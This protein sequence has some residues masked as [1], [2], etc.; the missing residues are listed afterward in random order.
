MIFV[1]NLA[2]TACFVL[3]LLLLLKAH[4]APGGRPARSFG[5][6]DS[7]ALLARAIQPRLQ[8]AD[9]EDPEEI[10][11][12]VKA[13]KSLSASQKTFKGLDGA[14]HEMYQRTHTVDTVELTVKGRATRSAARV[15]ATATA[16]GA[17]ELCEL[18]LH[19]ETIVGEAS[20]VENGTLVG[21]D[22]LVNS[23]EYAR[24]GH[25]PL[26]CLVLYDPSYRGPCGKD[27]GTI[28]D[29][30]END[31]TRKK[32][33]QVEGQ[34]LIA[35]GEHVELADMFA[36]L[37]TQP[38]Y[39][40]LSRGPEAVAI[41]PALHDAAST[42]VRRLEPVLREYNTSAVHFAGHGMAGGVASISAAILN[43][44]I[45]L[46]NEGAKK[47]QRKG[48]SKLKSKEGM[49][50]GIS[51]DRTSAVVLGCPPCFSSNVKA[52]YITFVMYGDDIVCRITP[53]SFERFIT[54][55]R[56]AMKRSG[57][58]GKR[59]NF[60]ADAVSLATTNLKS[61]AVGSEGEETRLAIPGNAYLVRP[62]RIGG[63]YSIHEIGNQ[64]KG[65]REALRAAVL[66]QL[67]DILLSRSLWRHHQLE[68]YIRGLD[69]VQLRGI[70]DDSDTED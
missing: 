55:T 34:L 31:G 12:I 64:L 57:L 11:R 16:L 1:T 51:K 38:R 37:E 22:M 29:A 52:L 54:R 40:G 35:L 27:Y 59:I 21:R 7:Y 18:V 49:L 19:P 43:G 62:R 41:Q 48:S 68:S 4:G 56:R 8:D 20:F 67:N 30:N 39:V 61:H 3:A 60:M 26:R 44:E 23:T 53:D 42:L 47:R 58:I 25:F 66:W 33:K 32:Q 17:C 5:P 45:P 50:Q 46:A 63:S 65:G 13:L 10:S 36:L 70:Q 14:A 24:L 2:Q 6:R 9:N 69:R 28:A 15:G